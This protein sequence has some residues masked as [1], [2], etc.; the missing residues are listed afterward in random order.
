M[1]L[2]S[3]ATRKLTIL[4][5]IGVMLS[6]V[7]AQSQQLLDYAPFAGYTLRKGILGNDYSQPLTSC[8]SGKESQLPAS[9]TKLRASITYNADEYKRAFHLDS[10]AQATFL[11]VGNVGVEA[12]YGQETG[13]SGSAF[14]VILEAYSEHPALTVDDVQWNTPY[15]EL[16]GSGDPNKIKQVRQSCGDR[17]IQTV[18]NEVRLFAVLHVSAQKRS[19]LLTFAGKVNANIKMDVSTVTAAL[20]GDRNISSA[21]QSGAITIE[22]FSQGLGGV[23]PTAAVL[24]ITTSDGLT[25]IADKLA[26]HLSS[27]QPKGQP[28]KYQLAPYPLMPLEDLNDERMIRALIDLKSAFEAA[29]AR[30]ANVLAL[31]PPNV[32]PR[33]LVLRQPQADAALANVQAALKKF[34]DKVAEAHRLCRM[35]NKYKECSA[36]YNALPPAPATIPV[37]LPPLVPPSVTTFFIAVNGSP[38]PLAHHALLISNAK[39]RTLFE[40]AKSLNV[41]ALN[42]DVVAYVPSAYMSHIEVLST[43]PEPIPPFRN[44][45]FAAGRL[46]PEQILLPGYFPANSGSGM[47]ILHADA[48]RPC[49]VK[50]ANG[51]ASI[52]EECFTQ[53]GKLFTAAL[54]SNVANLVVST[55]G[56]TDQ[57]YALPLLVSLQDCFTVPQTII[58][59]W[60]GINVV[61]SKAAHIDAQFSLSLPLVQS[62]GTLTL[63]A[64]SESYDLKGWEQLRQDRISALMKFGADT[65][66]GPGA[67]SPHIP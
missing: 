2:R 37:E 38:L 34:G 16:I 20:G 31:L 9:S 11:N 8:I 66:A 12:R 25:A 48:D 62:Q 67:C 61:R 60:I 64:D 41:A 15:K 27:L 10:S 7:T 17:F 46:V 1:H 13:N 53:A 43:L 55:E 42:V 33:R 18:F 51:T 22:I 4:S 32:D 14:D 47:I 26:K 19:D 52:P 23:A 28:V 65:P 29:A 24:D 58:I 57:N 3:K 39:G 50:E 45:Q 30:S 36:A 35:T 6:D 40:A 44:F 56:R 54:L 5:V 63:A 21:N 59:G 49:P